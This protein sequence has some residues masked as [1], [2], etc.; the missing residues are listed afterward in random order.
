MLPRRTRELS[1]QELVFGSFVYLV[2]KLRAKDCSGEFFVERFHSCSAH[3]ELVAFAASAA[4]VAGTA[5]D[6]VQEA[7][8]IAEFA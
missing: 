7:L 3:L 4:L 8:V 6:V 2:G 5:D 1:R